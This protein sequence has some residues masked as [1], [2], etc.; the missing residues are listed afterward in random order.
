MIP[1]ENL[2]ESWKKAAGTRAAELVED[3]M[4]VGLGTGTTAHYFIT[5]LGQ[6][7]QEGLQIKGAVSSSLGS[8]ELAKKVGIP[9]TTLDFNPTLDLYIDGADE[10]DPFLR[11]VKGGGGALL[12]EKIVATAARRFVVIADE[13]KLV[14][15][16]GTHCPIPVEVVPF[17]ITPVRHRL[18]ALGALVK[19]RQKP[20]SDAP[21]ITDN[22]N[23]IL[24]CTFP[25][26]VADPEAIDTAMQRIVG[27]VDTG[28]FLKM[29]EEAIIAGKDGIKVLRPN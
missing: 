12:R 11:L 1:H 10:I 6:R 29:A 26:G 25:D 18:E 13:T 24:D 21:F 20:A 14:Q 23:V 22:G 17:A 5:A 27:L 4:L 2:L 28:F 3:G 7:I 16:L 9:V 15:R 19:L 8:Q